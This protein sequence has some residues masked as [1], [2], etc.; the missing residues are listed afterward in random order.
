MSYEL[1]L[2]INVYESTIPVIMFTIGKQGT[3]RVL[4]QFYLLFWTQ[5]KQTSD[6]SRV[7]LALAILGMS[8]AV[9]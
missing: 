9:G 6:D 4:L 8:Y 3:W 7:T 1:S 2:F 5:K